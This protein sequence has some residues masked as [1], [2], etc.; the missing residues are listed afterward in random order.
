MKNFVGDYKPT[1]L[2]NDMEVQATR[3]FIK[4]FG[5]VKVTICLAE[6]ENS[7]E[8][9][10]EDDLVLSKFQHMI[11]AMPFLPPTDIERVF[12][13]V[14]MACIG[15]HSNFI[16]QN[17]KYIQDNYIGTRGQEGHIPVKLWNQFEAIKEDSCQS[18]LLQEQI[19][20]TL[21]TKPTRQQELVWATIG[22]FGLEDEL[23]AVRWREALLQVEVPDQLY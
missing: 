9:G 16:G 12:N 15:Q 18:I 13:T 22:R 6:G 1:S 19:K 2:L 8:S 23:H 5:D 17:L 4:V 11:S 10:E 14:F 7:N 3:A 21:K 20:D